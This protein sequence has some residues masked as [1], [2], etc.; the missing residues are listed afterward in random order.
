M[1]RP[2][3]RPQKPGMPKLQVVIDDGP[4]AG[5]TIATCALESDAK[6]IVEM[7]N[8]QRTLLHNESGE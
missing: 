1:K 7:W 6:L 8:W 2:K 4:N 5:M 3:R